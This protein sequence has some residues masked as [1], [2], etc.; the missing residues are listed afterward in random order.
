MRVSVVYRAN[1]LTCQYLANNLGDGQAQKLRILRAGSYSKSN[2]YDYQ[3]KLRISYVFEGQKLFMYFTFCISLWIWQYFERD[4]STYWLLL[5]ICMD[6]M[7]GAY[8]SPWLHVFKFDAILEGSQIS[9]IVIGS[10][11]L[12]LRNFDKYKICLKIMDEALK[13]T[14]PL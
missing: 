9:T 13:W 4:S 14:K 8:I 7:Q 2:L 1:Q 6:Y 10:R 12:V 11:S 3:Q 5:R